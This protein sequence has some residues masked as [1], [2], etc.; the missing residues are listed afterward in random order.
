MLA[1]RGVVHRPCFSRDGEA[2]RDG[3][4]EVRH[5]RQLGALPAQQGPEPSSWTG[6]A[7]RTGFAPGL[8]PDTIR[9]TNR[10]TFQQVLEL[11]GEPRSDR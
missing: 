3:H 5:L 9:T 8:I 1:S 2:W 11:A 7:A 10:P 4:A 6:P